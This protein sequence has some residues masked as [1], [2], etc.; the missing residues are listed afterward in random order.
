GV[1]GTEVNS[2]VVYNG[3]LYGG[4]LPRSEVCRYDGQEAWTSLVRFYSPPGWTPVAPGENGGD[5]NEWSRL[6]SLTIYD[7]K[8][9]ASTGNCT[10]N[11]G[12]SPLGDSRGKVFCMEAGKCVSYDRDLG[13]GWKHLAAV[14][15][16]GR[17]KL[18]IDGKLVA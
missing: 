9:F 10:S 13:T 16:R 12:D 1:D 5:L 15:E 18:Y 6:T 17:L 3:K 7:G 11:I 14:R 8:L 2:L 4:S